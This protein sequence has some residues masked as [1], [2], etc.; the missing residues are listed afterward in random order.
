VT[1]VRLLLAAALIGSGVI[2][3]SAQTAP[4]AV[5]TP[6]SGT[7]GTLRS[8]FNLPPTGETRFLANEVILDI[9]AGV[10]TQSLD[11]IAA[12]HHMTRLETRSFRMTGRTLHR[13]RL[14]GGGTVA[15]MI[16]GVA[17]ERQ[18]AGAQ[19]NYVYALQ[20]QADLPPANRE[21]YVPEKLDLT[22]AHRMA[23]G[24]RFWSR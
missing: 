17:G 24:T 22:A 3:A 12:R 7:T 8:R 5:A 23:T 6:R 2:Q 4:A 21:Q 11:T 16:R 15:A 20:Q 9:P 13:W 10:S 18:I 14:D 19:P 1:L